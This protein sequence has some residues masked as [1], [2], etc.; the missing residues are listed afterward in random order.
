MASPSSFLELTAAGADELAG[1]VAPGVA[2][3]SR[4]PSRWRP[5]S[6]MS[7]RASTDSWD[8]AAGRRA[9]RCA[10]RRA[11][12]A[13][14]AGRGLLDRA[15]AVR[16]GA[17][18]TLP[19]T[20]ATGDRQG[21]RRRGGAAARDRTDAV[22]VAELSEDRRAPG[23]P[24]V[25]PTRSAAALAGSRRPGGGD[26][27]PG[28]SHRGRADPG[29]PRPRGSRGRR[30]AP[31]RPGGRPFASTIRRG[32]YSG[33]AMRLHSSRCVRRPRGPRRGLAAVE[34]L[35]PETR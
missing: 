14:P 26:D 23:D 35:H 13:R 33:H 22:D 12:H 18:P 1:P 11:V 30:R 24:R 4:S 34:L 20:S 2:L 3:R 29:S 6:R 16:D 10:S 32:R 15:L 21:I 25:R 31:R 19:P 9:S 8:A 17:R 28:E 27:R 5:P 7:A